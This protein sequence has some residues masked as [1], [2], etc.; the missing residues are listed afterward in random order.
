MILEKE[1][2]LSLSVRMTRRAVLNRTRSMGSE[3]GI[4]KSR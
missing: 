1:G 2:L 3:E 4:R